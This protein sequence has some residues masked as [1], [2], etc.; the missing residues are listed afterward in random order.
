LDLKVGNATHSLVS[1]LTPRQS[2]D[3]ADL[4]ST[5]SFTIDPSDLTPTA[6]YRVR[7]L[8][9]DTTQ[10]A[11]FPET[12]YA[13]LAARAMQP[14][15]VVLVP[16][17]AG[18]FTPRSGSAELEALKRRLVALYPLTDVELS[19]AAPVT[20]SYVVNGDGDG[21]DAALNQIYALRDAAAPPQNV[22][23]FGMLAPD[24]SY[25][26]YCTNGCILG[27][28]N[29]ADADDQ[30]SRGA[31][32]VT[33]FPDGSGSDDAWDTVAHELGHALGRDHA[34]CGVDLSDTDSEWPDDQAHRNAGLGTYGYD[35]A[36]ARF[37]KPRTYRDVMSYCT[38]V[39]IS[40]YTY[41][42]IFERLDHIQAQGF[43]ALS[44]E[45]P[46]LYRLARVGRHGDS[47]WLGDRVKRGSAARYEL[48]L[49]DAQGSPMAKVV[50]QV[51][52]VDHGPGAFVWLPAAQLARSGATSVDLTPLG[53]H[54]LAL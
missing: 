27:Y 11:R 44:L 20:L 16:F 33:V 50:A 29:I 5:F 53:G 52:R 2:S 48:A 35:F 4:A 41:Q 36:Q 17:V 19:V 45:A 12:G 21:W 31:I 32:G 14:L 10:L 18:G 40:D 3:D 26:D 1:E 37:L 24:K 46:E 13:P 34:P 7:V 6:S 43:R 47:A 15:E 38:P 49:L 9:Q 23:Y 28:S 42:G 22:F 8:E 51:A 25:D 54:Q 30:D 39:W